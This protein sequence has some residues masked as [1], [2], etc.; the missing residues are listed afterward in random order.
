MK[1]AAHI[2]AALCLLAGVL[3]A[4]SC[5]ADPPPPTVAPTPTPAP[6]PTQAASPTPAPS[7]IPAPTPTEEAVAEEELAAP[8]PALDSR[9]FEFTGTQEWINSEPLTLKGLA[10]SGEVTLIDFWTYT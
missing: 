7:P 6:T 9:Q 8:L 4:A 2:A 10:E 1:R 3:A 5:G